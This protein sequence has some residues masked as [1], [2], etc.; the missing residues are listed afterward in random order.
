[1]KQTVQKQRVAVYC[2]VA[3]DSEDHSA[4]LA[5]QGAYYTEMVGQH[6]EWELAGIYADRGIAGADRQNQKEFKKMLTACKQGKI[7]LILVRSISR[8]A[9]NVAD[10]LETVRMLNASN[11]GVI[12]EKEGIDTRAESGDVC[13]ALYCEIARRESESITSNLIY[14]VGQRM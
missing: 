13:V 6:P 1:M 9:R 12:F 7:D 4:S 2:R 14:P 11:V 5:V 10:C 3:A 8:F